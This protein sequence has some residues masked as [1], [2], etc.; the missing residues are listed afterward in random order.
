MHQ[1]L[2]Q[3]TETINR[4]QLIDNIITFNKPLT[5][6]V[7]GFIFIGM[8]TERIKDI[9]ENYLE[10]KHVHGEFKIKEIR[11]ETVSTYDGLYPSFEI[12]YEGKQPQINIAQLEI[13]Q[14]IEKYT[15]LKKNKDYWIGISWEE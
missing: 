7:R 1:N 13:T 12:I 11:N 6:P 15:G 14:E 3:T 4:E 9:I 5:K 2:E 10:M 8:T